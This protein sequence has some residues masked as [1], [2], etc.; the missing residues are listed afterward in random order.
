MAWIRIRMDPE[1]LPGSETRKI[2]SWIWNKSLW[3]QQL[4]RLPSW[5]QDPYGHFRILDPDKNLCR[6]KTL[7]GTSQG[8]AQGTGAPGAHLFFSPPPSP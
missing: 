4:Y 6:P 7:F 8:H 5:I 3:I 1:L 2:Q